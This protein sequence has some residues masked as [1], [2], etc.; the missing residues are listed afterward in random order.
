MT[1]VSD[2]LVEHDIEVA[3]RDPP[4][5]KLAQAMEM[6]ESG[7]RLKRAALRHVNKNASDQELDQALLHWLCADD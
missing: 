7:L 3:R 4:A 2:P 5:V 6:M 1:S